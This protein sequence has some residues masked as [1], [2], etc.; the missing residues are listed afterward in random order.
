MF[1]IQRTSPRQKSC[2]KHVPVLLGCLD[3]GRTTD[4]RCKARP[5]CVT[6]HY[7]HSSALRSSTLHRHSK[8]HVKIISKLIWPSKRPV[9]IALHNHA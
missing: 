6:L 2:K 1:F 4:I 3:Q 9:T 7:L 8:Q 5:N